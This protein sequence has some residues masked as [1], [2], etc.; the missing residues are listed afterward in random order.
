M[1]KAYLRL[2]KLALVTSLSYGSIK[3]AE[4]YKE[5]TRVPIMNISIDNEKNIDLGEFSTKPYDYSMVMVLSQRE[6]MIEELTPIVEKYASIFCLDK[7]CVLKQISLNTNNFN[8][9]S[10]IWN[11][12]I[13]K[14]EYK[15]YELKCET[16]TYNFAE[17]LYRNTMC[18][19]YDDFKSQV[20]FLARDMYKY[21][22]NYSEVEVKR[23]YDIPPQVD[24]MTIREFVYETADILGV[25]GDMVLAI[26]CLESGYFRYT[27]NNDSFGTGHSFNNIYEGIIFGIC[28]LKFNYIDCGYTSLESIATKYCPPSV[29]IWPSRVRSIEYSLTHGYKLYDEYDKELIYSK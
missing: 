9:H 4:Y 17:M 24:D 10:F 14:V 28:N 26:A 7:D 29:D 6:K 11:K 12:N 1:K 3:G 13:S 18:E 21:P 15:P 27:Y 5:I 23:C 22:G 8:N 2:I 20:F 25:D 19:K 16:R